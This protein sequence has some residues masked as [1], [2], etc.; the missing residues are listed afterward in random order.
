[1]TLPWLCSA[2]VVPRRCVTAVLHTGVHTQRRLMAAVTDTAF[3]GYFAATTSSWWSSD[4]R[5]KEEGR[6]RG[7][8]PTDERLKKRT[9]PSKLAA[10]LYSCGCALLWRSRDEAWP[11]SFGRT[12]PNASHRDWWVGERRARTRREL[13]RQKQKTKT[14]PSYQPLPL[15]RVPP[16]PP[17][18]GGRLMSRR[19]SVGR[20]SVQQ[21]KKTQ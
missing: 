9:S 13:H 1:M 4:G 6:W 7:T 19:R 15:S 20:A 5:E 18:Y 14:H 16:L 8:S 12:H 21:M 3:I 11:Q 17:C 2:A 10:V